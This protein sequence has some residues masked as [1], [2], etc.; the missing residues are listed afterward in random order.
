M[1][2]FKSYPIRAIVVLMLWGMFATGAA[3]AQTDETGVRESRTTQST[4]ADRD[5]GLA[6]GESRDVFP[7]LS[8]EGKRRS[9][10]SAASAA[11]PGAAR[12]AVD[13]DFWFYTAD[14]ILFNDH[15]QDGYFHGIDLL[16]DAD[17]IY[18]FAEVYAVVYLSLDGGPWQEYAA[19]D[20]FVISG[21]TS[22]DEFV[23]VTEL[24]SGYPTGSYD[25][26]IELF[27]TFDGAFVASFGPEDTSALAFLSLEDSNRDIAITETIV[28][29]DGGGGAMS[30]ALL[31]ALL[32]VGWPAIWQRWHE[33]SAGSA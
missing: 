28:V 18:D 25:L 33:S 31:L 30:W 7:A 29:H 14:V 24:V 15:D 23:V 1:A 27:D 13:S 19:T 22:D 2:A 6:T 12:S 11:K 3:L 20:N 26:L 9:G 5:A 32:I 8:T 4:R 10:K 17:T 16:F 21:A